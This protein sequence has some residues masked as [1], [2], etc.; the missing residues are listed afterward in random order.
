MAEQYELALEVLTYAIANSGDD[1]FIRAGRILARQI[2]RAQ[3]DARPPKETP[4]AKTH[5]G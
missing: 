1:F 4:H 3:I 2:K 5:T